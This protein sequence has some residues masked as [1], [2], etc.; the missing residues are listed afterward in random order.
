[1]EAMEALRERRS[2]RVYEKKPIPKDL[3]ESVIDA[4]RLAPTANNVQ[5]W[6][7]IVVT[8]AGV[9][10]QIA[11]LTDWGKF[12]AQSG[13]CVAVYCKAVKHY[14]E[15]GSAAIENIMIAAHSLGLGT[16]WVAGYGKDY[17]EPVR[18]LL[19]VP[20]GYKLVGLISLGYPAEKPVAKGKR[21]L[22]SVLHWE[23]Y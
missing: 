5:P 12:I 6:E 18:R 10:R 8:E 3:I 21:D 9:R 2:V 1:M 20:E 19:G 22:S 7:F 17:G 4:G 13:A 11:E 14:L 23:K 15:D 16:C